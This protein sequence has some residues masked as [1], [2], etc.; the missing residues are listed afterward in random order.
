MTRFVC[1]GALRG[2]AT[3]LIYGLPFNAGIRK[4]TGREQPTECANNST[5]SAKIKGLWLIEVFQYRL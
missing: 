5:F 3:P 1:H 4:R 2:T